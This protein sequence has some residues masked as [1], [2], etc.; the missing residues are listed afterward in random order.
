MTIRAVLAL[1]LVVPAASAW[2]DP[3]ASVTASVERSDRNDEWLALAAPVLAVP[4]NGG[5][6][7]GFAPS[8]SAF[9]DNGHGAIGARFRGGFVTDHV[10]DETS[11]TGTLGFV[12]R[13]G[14]RGPWAEVGGGGGKHGKFV[15]LGAELGVGYDFM[16]GT[17]TVS[18][19][20][21]YIHFDLSM[22]EDGKTADGVLAGIGTYFGRATRSRSPRSSAVAQR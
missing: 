17:T 2:A 19:S 9:L 14:M 8:I 18:V 11:T 12:F 7:V 22:S 21:R 6:S 5:A 4:E 3:A 16:L 10:T 20:A 15:G 13:V 1:T